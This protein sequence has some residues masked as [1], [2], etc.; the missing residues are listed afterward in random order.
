MTACRKAITDPALAERFWNP[1]SEILPIRQ[2]VSLPVLALAVL[3]WEA[4]SADPL[5]L[6]T[7][8]QTEIPDL[9]LLF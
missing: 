8:I 9:V 7:L 4:F 1:F 6:R 2:P 3:F 5:N